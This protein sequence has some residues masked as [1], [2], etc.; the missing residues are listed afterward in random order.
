MPRI[1]SPSFQT[2]IE[3]LARRAPDLVASRHRLRE[4]RS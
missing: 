1:D 2:L 4:A 3:H